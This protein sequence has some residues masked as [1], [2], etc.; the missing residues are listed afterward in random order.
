[1]SAPK[2]NPGILDIAPYKA[3][4]AKAEGF[5]KPVK[6]SA[7][8]NALGCSPAA[9]RAYN[10]TSHDLN[11]YPDPNVSDLRNAIAERCNIESSRIVFGTGSDEI[12]SMIC[13]AYLMPGDNMA[14]PEHGFAAWGI[15]GRAASAQVKSA[16]EKNYTA[17]VDALLVAVDDRTRVVFVANPANPTGT[18]LPF[19]EIKRLHAGLRPDI[20]FLLDSAYVDYARDLLPHDADIELARNSE[21]VVVTRTFSKLHGLAALRIG[22]A[23]APQPIADALNRIRLPFNVSRPGQAAAVAAMADKDFVERSIA[24]AEKGRAVLAKLL[25]SLGLEVLPSY[26]NFVTARF[27]TSVGITALE[28]E[29][30]LAE[31]GVLVR[32]IANYGLPDCLRITIG[33]DEEMARL[34]AALR[35]VLA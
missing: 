12:F 20:I 13:Q 35:K 9:E 2:P 26:S 4:K 22:W 19:D 24:H 15:A 33:T 5:D 29:K 18:C 31:Q 8:E 1:M 30:R 32:Y 25:S 6:L 16:P 28:A 23:Y 34:E 10:A 21:N 7:N 14:Q 27:P 11:L 17:D 3:G